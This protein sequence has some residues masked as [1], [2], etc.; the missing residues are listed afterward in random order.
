MKNAIMILVALATSILAGCASFEVRQKNAYIDDEGNMAIVEFGT[1]SKDHVFMI[2]SPGNGKM[3]EYSSNMMVR[4]TLPDKEKILAYRTL[5]SYPVGTMYMTDDKE[6]IFLTK[7][8]ACQIGALL[9][10]GSDYL[11]V[12]EGNLTKTG[13]EEGAK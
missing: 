10:D 6:Y 13:E 9:Q 2:P 5:N 4:I 12:F 3:V 8:F 1:R 11:L 7:G